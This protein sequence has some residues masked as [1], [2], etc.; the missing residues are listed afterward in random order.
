MNASAKGGADRLVPVEIHNQR[1]FKFALIQA[2][3]LR[4]YH[5]HVTNLHRN[6]TEVHR[7]FH[8]ARQ[9][10]DRKATQQFFHCILNQRGV[11]LQLLTMGGAV[12]QEAGPEA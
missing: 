8:F 5:N 2:I 7:H 11:V 1:I 4:R 6:T 9:Y 10:R 12:C 3:Q